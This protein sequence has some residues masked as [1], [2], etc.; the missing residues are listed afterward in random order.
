MPKDTEDWALH[1]RRRRGKR[2]RCDWP[3]PE[4]D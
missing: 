3:G 2:P 4:K 1:S